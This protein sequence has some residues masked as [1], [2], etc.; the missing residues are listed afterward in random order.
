[1]TTEPFNPFVCVG[2]GFNCLT[3]AEYFWLLDSVW[4]ETGA[5]DGMLCV[6]CCEVRLGRQLVGKDFVDSPPNVG[7]HWARSERLQAR[8]GA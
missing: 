2:C 5:G 4:R 6:G 1:V 3:G 7:A 8:L